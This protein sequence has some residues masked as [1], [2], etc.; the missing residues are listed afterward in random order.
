MAK[1]IT[2]VEAYISQFSPEIQRT[3]T[4]L[5]KIIQKAAP[6]IKQSIKWGMPS[7]HFE[8]NIFHFSVQKKHIGLHCGTDA[9]AHFE[10]ELKGYAA[11]KGTF[12]LPLGTPIPEKLITEMVQFNVENQ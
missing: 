9:I 7:F 3:L 12:Q 10:K 2:T 11:S 1:E 8:K 6:G 5:Q 4:Q